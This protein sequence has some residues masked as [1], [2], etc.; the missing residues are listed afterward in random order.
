MQ[1]VSNNFNTQR[2]NYYNIRPQNNY[3]N[4]NRLSFKG[5]FGS[6]IFVEGSKELTLIQETAFFRQTQGLVF[7]KDYAK[8]IFN[9][10]GKL[11]ILDGACSTGEETWSLAMLFDDYPDVEIT[12][13]DLGVQAIKQANQGVFHISKPTFL[14]NRKIAQKDAFKD[15]YLAFRQIGLSKEQRRYKALF[16]SYFKPCPTPKEEVQNNEL[17]TK[18]YLINPSKK[19]KCNFV[20]GDIMNLD[21]I[22]QNNSV[23]ILL[24]RNALYHLLSD[25]SMNNNHRVP[26]SEKE[27]NETLG[28]ILEGIHNKLSEN[29]ILVLGEREYEQITKNGEYTHLIN[30]TTLIEIFLAKGFVPIFS[31]SEKKGLPIIWKKV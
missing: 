29:G 30:N 8:K 11:R 26:K 5:H 27:I 15:S 14:Y 19:S 13:F 2:N 6:E 4:K 17:K 28:K 12:G 9:G 31:V 16:K 7:A 23:D 18:Y 3:F 1:G 25:K 22:A 20:Q 10:K 24:F 21:N